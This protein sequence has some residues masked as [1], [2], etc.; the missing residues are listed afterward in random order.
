MQQNRTWSDHVTGRAECG[1]HWFVRTS[2]RGSFGESPKDVLFPTRRHVPVKASHPASDA[3]GEMVAAQSAGIVVIP[4]WLEP[5]GRTHGA[6]VYGH[7]LHGYLP[8]SLTAENGEVSVCGGGRVAGELPMTKRSASS[9]SRARFGLDISRIA[10]C[11][12]NLSQDHQA[13]PHS[14]S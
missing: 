13:P 8:L 10:G 12:S 5:A 3:E 11:H 1:C 4:R 14:L 2:G 9:S 6:L 7:Y